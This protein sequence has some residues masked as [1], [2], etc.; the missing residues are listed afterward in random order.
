MKK[1]MKKKKKIIWN[2]KITK[3]IKSEDVKDD[4]KEKRR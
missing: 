4:K 3:G 2:Q 1:E